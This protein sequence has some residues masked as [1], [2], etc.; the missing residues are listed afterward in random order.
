MNDRPKIPTWNPEFIRDLSEKVY[1][2]RLEDECKGN[3]DRMLEKDDDGGKKL[4]NRAG[5]YDSLSR[6]YLD[7]LGFKPPAE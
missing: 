5:F 6:V 7:L 1:R 3:T 4:R 2:V